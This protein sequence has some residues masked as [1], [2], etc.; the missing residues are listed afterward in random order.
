[1]K[2]LLLD[3][4]FNN[5]ITILAGIG[6]FISA[7][8][9]AYTVVEVKKQRRSSYMPELILE[10]YGVYWYWNKSL[11]EDHKFEFKES[12]LNEFDNKVQN[13]KGILVLFSLENIGLGVAKYINIKWDFDMESALKKIKQ[14]L[15]NDYHLDDSDD[16]IWIKRGEEFIGW[17][18]RHQIR[19]VSL[20]FILP[21][22]NV[23]KLSIP[24]VIIK[25]YI[26]YMIFKNKLYHEDADMIYE[27]LNDL[28]L[29]F[30]TLQYTDFMKKSYNKQFSIKFEFASTSLK[31]FNPTD[32]EL[33][34]FYI[35]VKEF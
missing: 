31:E 17:L 11:K 2:D 6:T 28:P 27:D 16:S 19:N 18:P 8:I 34:F 23:K 29:L 32:D 26:Y 9:A 21:N 14:V 25:T 22:K 4:S 35:K 15:P 12:A 20:D 30:M 33:G 10:T 24:N 3:P 7:L 5:L 1:M 13:K